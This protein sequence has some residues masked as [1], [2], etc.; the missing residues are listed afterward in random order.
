M[1][2][3]VMNILVATNLAQFVQLQT[4][5]SIYRSPDWL[6]AN[7]PITFSNRNKIEIFF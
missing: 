7:V 2:L 6:T 1:S 3:L 4:T 5:I